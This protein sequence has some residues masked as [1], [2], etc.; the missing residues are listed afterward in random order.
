MVIFLA[1]FLGLHMFIRSYCK[2][3][4]REGLGTRVLYPSGAS[5]LGV[6]FILVLGCTLREGCYLW[7]GYHWEQECT[8][9]S[10][11]RT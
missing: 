4:M 3:R 5:F 11:K 10:I 1:L 6:I 2:R 8:M 9:M 7:Y